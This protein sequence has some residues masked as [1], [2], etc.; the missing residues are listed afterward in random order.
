MLHTQDS[1]HDL[2]DGR[3]VLHASDPVHDLH[4]G[5]A[6]VH[7]QGS[8]LR[9]AVRQLHDLPLSDPLCAPSGASLYDTLRPALCLPP[10][11]GSGLRST[12]TDVQRS[13]ADVQRSRRSRLRSADARGTEGEC[14][15]YQIERQT[16]LPTV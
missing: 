12:R 3:R 8:V 2:P 4:D 14:G 1:V 6:D 11:S 7:S 9:A 16:L 15:N 13:A 10:G 5:T